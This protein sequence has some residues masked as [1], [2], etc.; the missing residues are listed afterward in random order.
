MAKLMHIQ[1]SPRGRRS[2]S[3]AVAASFVESYRAAHPGD[4]VDTLA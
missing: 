1:S 3:L 2:A 4:T